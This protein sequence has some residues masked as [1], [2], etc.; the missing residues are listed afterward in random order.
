MRKT[1]FCA[2]SAP[3]KGATDGAVTWHHV[4][5]LL[6]LTTTREPATDLGFLLVKHPDRVHRFDL[7]TGTAYVC[8]PEAT[9][10]RC[11][12]ALV[13]DVD[14]GRLG[15]RSGT[16]DDFTLGRFVN[17]R[18]YAASSLLSG[19]INRA[20]KSAMRGSSPDKPE[21]AA[22]AIPL[23]VHIPALRCRGGAGLAERLFAPLGWAVRA[24]PVPLDPTHPEW[25]DSRYLDLTLAGQVR[26]ADALNQLYV[27]LP[28][29][30]DA[31]HYWVAPD[32]IEKLLRAGQGWLTDHPE[33]ELITRRYL[34][35][36]REL[37]TEAQIRLDALRAADD[38]SE[39]DTVD[40]VE[41]STTDEDAELSPIARAV[42][43][44]QR[45]R[46]AVRA[47]L[48]Q[49]GAARVLDLGCGAG[50]LLAD[51]VRDKRY[52]ALVGVDVA[53]APLKLAER[54]LH[55]ER[56]R[57]RVSLLQSALTYADD[58][59]IGYDAAVLM[60]VIEHVDQPR[61]PAVA[62]SVFGHAR[63]TTVIVTTPN[64]VYNARYEGM[65]EG[66]LRHHDH[67]FEWTRAEFTAWCT[68]VA[69]TYGYRFELTPVGDD[70]PEVGSPTQ[71][72]TFTLETTP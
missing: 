30:D 2:G 36:R 54:R 31:K 71:L 56:T 34:A 50:A 26:L 48:E 45:R 63:P 52:T 68:E 4:A 37:A 40:A 38:V 25:G 55:P 49:C 66:S 3:G 19:A 22:T 60:E 15:G 6:T 42:P 58:R 33:Q 20:F 1:L 27:L 41:E 21:L 18:P 23:E 69:G 46:E 57:G 5:V 67:R 72:A 53:T 13:L 61:L 9:S 47:A 28:V 35:H 10:Q 59:L 51:L 70:D 11:T 43:L 8:F 44:A 17:D 64:V 62:A 29:C 65:A 32:E 16:R 14:P 7:P 24:T 12:A 39:P